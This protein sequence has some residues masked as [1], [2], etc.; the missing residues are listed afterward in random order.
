M[1]LKWS[2]ILCAEFTVD[3][4]VPTQQQIPLRSIKNE[5]KCKYLCFFLWHD[6]DQYISF[7]SCSTPYKL[8]LFQQL[9][10]LKKALWVGD[11]TYK[12]LGL[13]CTSCPKL[14]KWMCSG[15]NSSHGASTGWTP[16]DC[17]RSFVL[18]LYLHGGKFVKETVFLELHTKRIAPKWYVTNIAPLH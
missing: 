7:T 14:I 1:K 17:L 9:Y 13:L 4:K 8:V 5:K 6:R 3:V 16:H 12:Y 15:L 11:S 18:C 10:S 2:L